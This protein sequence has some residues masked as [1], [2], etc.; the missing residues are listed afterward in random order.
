MSRALDILHAFSALL[1]SRRSRWHGR[2]FAR[3]LWMEPGTSRG[4]QGRSFDL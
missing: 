3:R 4:G 2:E 1:A